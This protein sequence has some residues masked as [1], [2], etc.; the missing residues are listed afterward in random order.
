MWA[1]DDLLVIDI[2]ESFKVIIILS[3]LQSFLRVDH[4]DSLLI[5]SFQYQSF[6]EIRPKG[7]FAALPL[8]RNFHFEKFRIDILIDGMECDRCEYALLE[9]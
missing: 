7:I 5:Q 6:N 4:E 3:D 2:A 1:F 9:L 8:L